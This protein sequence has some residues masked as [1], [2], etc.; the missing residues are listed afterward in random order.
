MG[1]PEVDGDSS[2]ALAVSTRAP[3]APAKGT[4]LVL[5]TLA[6]GQSS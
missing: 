6:S 5:L 2:E 3:E 1:R 4:G